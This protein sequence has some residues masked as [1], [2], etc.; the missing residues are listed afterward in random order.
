MSATLQGLVFCAGCLVAG[1]GGGGYDGDTNYGGTTT[2]TARTLSTCTTSI[3]ADAPAF[4]A[5]YFK[6]VTITRG[7]G[8]VTITTQDLPP[9]L[10]YYYGSGNAN[11]TAFDTQGGTRSPNPNTLYAQNKS[12]TVPDAPT[13]RGLTITSAMIDKTAGN[14]GNEYP[15]G[16][17]GVA[18]DSVALYTGTAAPGDDIDDEKFTFDSYEAH[19]SGDGAYH[20]HAPTP[21]PLEV[22][23]DAGFVTTTT[24]GSAQVELYGILCD[25]TVVLGCTELDGTAPSGL[26]AQGGHVAD[27]IDS[28]GTTYFVARY[29]TH[30]CSNTA[31][32]YIYTPEIQ[33]YNACVR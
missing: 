13:A 31:K 30:V 17:I 8:A 27:I 33:Y 5:R 28:G 12:I 19:P 24:P 29:H 21:G 11:Y 20:Y 23:K 25:G 3:A 15:L 32:G 9:H 18:L 7:T 6:C 22:L 4:Y 2:A 16:A 1:C 26:D 14:D 10:S